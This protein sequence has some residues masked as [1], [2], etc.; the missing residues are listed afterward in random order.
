M[1]PLF[2]LITGLNNESKLQFVVLLFL[3]IILAI[4][5]SFSIFTIAPVVDVLMEN[6]PEDYSS[7]TK[8]LINL[9]NLETLTVAFSFIFFGI[10][11][12]LAGVGTVIV[13]YMV[14]KIKYSVI[15]HIMSDAFTQLF[16][17]KFSFFSESDMGELLN[18]FQRE[19]DKIGGAIGN[20]A[21]FGAN[22][23]Q[24]ILFLAVPFYISYKLTLIFICCA[25]IMCIPIWILNRRVYPLGVLNTETANS[26]SGILHQSFSAAKLIIAYGNQI[27]TSKRYKSL[28][29]DHA[30]VSIP[31]QTIVFAVSILFM[32]LGMCAALISIYWGYLLGIS[33][34]E[35]A[36]ILFAFFRM[37]PIA[38]SLFQIRAEIIGFIPA[39]EQLERLTSN[40][41]KYEE[42]YSSKIFKNFKDQISF[43]DLS[44]SYTKP[45]LVLKNINMQFNKNETTA[46][47]GRSGSGKTTIGDIL[48]GLYHPTS[49]IIKID[50]NEY[51]SFN[52]NSF[53]KHVGYVPQEPFLFDMSIKENMLWSKP[54]VTDKEI[55]EVLKLANLYDFVK[56]LKDQLNTIMGERGGKISGGQRQRMALARAMLRKPKILLLDEA[57]SALDN[58]SEKLIQSA[59]N[60]LASKTTIVIIAHRLS[61]IKNVDQVYV[62]DQGSILEQGSYKE[63]SNDKQSKFFEML[64]NSS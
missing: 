25:L 50:N 17:S 54:N 38:G 45:N 40:A 57:T 18:S 4:L 44:F 41:K 5:N 47:V 64:S 43:E 34:S 29:N 53:R 42:Y 32:P 1:K 2:D 55:W 9:F 20:I 31:F 11:I 21:K 26:V 16:K 6:Q 49:G 15:V 7:F 48:L 24:V 52:I 19:S 35:M 58:E 28:F 62:L 23:L 63:L 60:N 46:L 36:M 8:V 51:Q 33:L 56:N 3:V 12:I 14:F 22:L 30:N 13:Q 39:F 61:T 59:I 37:M 27:V 10:S